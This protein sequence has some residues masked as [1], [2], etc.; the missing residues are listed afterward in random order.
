MNNKVTNLK[1]LGV[2]IQHLSLVISPVILPKIPDFMRHKWHEEHPTNSDVN[3]EML[4]VFL[5][6]QIQI[7]EKT[8][9]SGDTLPS[10][11]DRRPNSNPFRMPTRRPQVK[12]S[13]DPKST[14]NNKQNKLALNRKLKTFEYH[15]PFVL[16]FHISC[17]R[18]IYK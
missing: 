3:I 14:G 18:N 1:T 9:E 7:F 13:A 11:A 17:R 15:E 8:V 4:L 6:K 2:T 10:S 12:A 5:E 16:I